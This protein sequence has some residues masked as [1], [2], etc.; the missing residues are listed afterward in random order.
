[1]STE[2]M[3]K[4]EPH[5]K[6]CLFD[7]F[8]LLEDMHEKRNGVVVGEA[9]Y[10][11]GKKL[12]QLYGISGD[13]V[14]GVPNSAM[15][16]AQGYS[17]ESGLKLSSPIIK[18]PIYGRSFT[19][20]SKEQQVFVARNK[21][22]YNPEQIENK[23]LVVIDDSIVRGTVA[24]VLVGRL[25]NLGAKEIHFLSAVAPVIKKCKFNRNKIK[26]LDE[27]IVNKTSDIQKFLGVDSLH[28]LPLSDAIDI[29]SDGT[30]CGQCMSAQGQY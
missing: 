28:F 14:F 8:Y 11:A 30:G 18:N 24:Q 1:M 23:R 27:L 2:R 5:V 26:E 21:F 22:F 9:R 19:Q 12:S 20:E 13:S 4:D 17:D 7:M 10:N 29:Y 6:T 16:I 3:S 15:L 25:K